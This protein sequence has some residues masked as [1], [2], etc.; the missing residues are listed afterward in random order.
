MEKNVDYKIHNQKQDVE[1]N[2][3]ILDMTIVSKRLSLIDIYGPKKDYPNFY[4]NLFK[5]ITDIGNESYII[6]GD[7]NLTLNPNS[8][9]FNYKHVNNPRACKSIMNK[10]KENNL[11]D[12]F[13]ELHPSLRI[14][15]WR[16][17]IL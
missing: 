10:I 12:T 14:H 6:C 13:R 5:I 11:F 4:E 1:G 7:F 16:R 15:K 17:K 9:C 2:L 8:D 3:L